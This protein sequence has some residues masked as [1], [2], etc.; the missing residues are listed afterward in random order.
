LQCSA[1]FLFEW[2]PNLITI[3]FLGATGRDVII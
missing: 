1:G 3:Y 2:L